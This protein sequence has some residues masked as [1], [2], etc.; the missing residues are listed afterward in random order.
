MDETF[1]KEI[2]KSS[3]E[4][5]MKRQQILMAIAINTGIVIA[6]IYQHNFPKKTL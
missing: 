6:K 2:G 4:H 5:Q 1:E 3:H